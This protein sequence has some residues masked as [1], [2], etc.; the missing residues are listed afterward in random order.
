[1]LPPDLCLSVC[2]FVCVCATFRMNTNFPIADPFSSPRIE[3]SVLY[4]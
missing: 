3:T 4:F 1:M 2:L